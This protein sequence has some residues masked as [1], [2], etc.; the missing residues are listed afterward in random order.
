MMALYQA[1]ENLTHEFDKVSVLY[2]G[3]QVFFGAVANAKPYFEDLGFICHPRQTTADFLTAVTDP[4]A[5]R[6]K[7]GW[8]ARA[9]RTPD[10]FVREWKKSPHY[11]QLSREMQQYDR[12]FGQPQ[13][14]LE[15][16]QRYQLTQKAR[17]QRKKSVYMVNVRAQLA[18]NLKR[19]FHRLVG[20]KTFLGAMAFSSIFLSVIMGSMFYN[21]P[22]TTSSFYSKGGALFFSLLF[23]AVQTLSEIGTQYAQRPIVQRQETYAMYHPFVDAVASMVAQY[24]YKLLVVTIFDLVIYFMANLKRQVGAFF[25]FWLTTYLAALVMSGYFRTLA[26]VTKKPES[27]MSLAGVSVLA[28]AIYTGYVIPKPSMHPWFK[29]I[30]YI[31]PLSYAFETLMANE[32]HGVLAV[33]TALVPSGPSLRNASPS[34]QVCAVTG[35]KPG[36]TF[37]NGD[38]YIAASFN[39]YYSHV[40]RNTGILGAFLVGFTFTFA[41]ATEFNSLAANK[42]DALVFR[43]GHEPENVR[44]ALQDGKVLDDVESQEDYGA[45]TEIKTNVSEIRGLVQSKDVFIWEQLS[46]DIATHDGEMRRLLND[47]SGYVKPGTLTALIGESGAGKTT[48]LNV[49]AQ[50][51]D[52]GVVSGHVSVNNSAPG[53]S[54]RRRTGYVQQQDVHLPESTVRE[55]L[56]FSATLRQPKD[57]PIEEKLAYV[58]NVIEILEMQDYAEAVIGVPGNG[59]DLEQRKRTTIGVELVAKPALLFVD[60]PTSGMDSQSAWSIVRLLRKLANAGQATLCTIHQPSSVLFD[61]FDRLLLLTKGGKTVFFGSIG[62]QG[63]NV[64]DYFESNGAFSC[65]TDANPAEYILDVIGAGASGHVDRDWNQMWMQSTG[66]KEAIAEIQA[67]RCEDSVAGSGSQAQ[68]PVETEFAM[69]WFS[70]YRAVQWRIYLHYWRNPT[71]IMGKVFLNVAAGLF[72]GF[73]FYKEGDS[74][75]GLQNKVPA[76]FAMLEH[77]SRALTES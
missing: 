35:A 49:L 8:E 7:S 41:L 4:H 39:Y 72:V 42:G 46:Y 64:I 69:P 2:L 17:R 53:R 15:E 31:D 21:L 28:F 37:V 60:E 12:D 54:F 74:V 20:D 59:L 70:Q 56:R 25:I 63:Q 45:L 3:R 71:Y 14:Q 62:D 43:K 24:P 65:P 38:D 55:A 76:S 50:R 6:I 36:Q 66:H 18:A 9:P 22:E 10:E 16:Y 26:A 32:F 23:N 1:G 77:G 33:C 75:Q 40:G 67:L 61:E 29:W 34:N 27:A 58:E 19:A 44:K 47:V 48:L 30:T 5:R 52:G 51:V 57:V 73:T 13:P 68:A 11:A